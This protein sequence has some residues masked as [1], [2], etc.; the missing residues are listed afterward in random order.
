MEISEQ[1]D[2][3]INVLMKFKNKQVHCHVLNDN[4]CTHARKRFHK[5]HMALT[6]FVSLC[7][8]TK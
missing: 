3:V 7:T 1:S 5:C 2:L 4:K 6:A 8:R